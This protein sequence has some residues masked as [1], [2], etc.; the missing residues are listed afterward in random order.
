MS[1]LSPMIRDHVELCKAMAIR[2]EELGEAYLRIRGVELRV[3]DYLESDYQRFRNLYFRVAAKDLRASEAELKSMHEV[4]I[5]SVATNA[6]LRNQP[7]PKVM[8]RED[9]GLPHA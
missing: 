9:A 2:I 6:A 4:A 5:W 7:L 1:L 3:P 8:W